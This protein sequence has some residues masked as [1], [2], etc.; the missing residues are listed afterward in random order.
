MQLAQT[1]SFVQ[2]RVVEPSYSGI[3]GE[4]EDER[5]GEEWLG[6]PRV[7]DLAGEGTTGIH[8]GYKARARRVS[9]ILQDGERQTC[10]SRLWP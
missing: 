7:D 5:A 3:S 1:L 9:T 6:A 10:R 8:P 4:E 2:A